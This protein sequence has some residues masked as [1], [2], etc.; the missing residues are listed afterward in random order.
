MERDIAAIKRSI[1]E[2]QDKERAIREEIARDDRE[3]AEKMRRIDEE[4]AQI[5]RE[6]VAFREKEELIVE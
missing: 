4:I 3:T 5:K 6:S 2:Q 1:A